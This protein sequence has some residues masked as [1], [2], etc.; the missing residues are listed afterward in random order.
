MRSAG[1]AQELPFGVSDAVEV[2][3]SVSR[4][5]TRIFRFERD[6]HFE[7]QID[8][9]VSLARLRARPWAIESICAAEQIVTTLLR[10]VG[11][12]F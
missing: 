1:L 6:R 10:A 7:D 8:L 4:A 3:V 5:W 2:K 9:S 11:R 12:R